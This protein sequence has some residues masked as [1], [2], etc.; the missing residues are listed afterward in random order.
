MNFGPMSLRGRCIV[1]RRGPQILRRN[2]VTILTLQNRN[3]LRPTRPVRECSMGVG[4]R[5]SSLTFRT[6][7]PC[8]LPVIATTGPIQD[9][10]AQAG[11]PMCLR[12]M[13]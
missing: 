11:T 7:C 1:N 2:Y 9:S 3:D 4:F 12:G 13:R 8:V 6:P 10:L 5:R